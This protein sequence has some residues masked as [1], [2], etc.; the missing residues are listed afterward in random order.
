MPDAVVVG[1]G[2][3]GLS[4]AIGLHRVGWRV[5]VLERAERF[6]P[7]GAGI[8]LWPNAVRALGTLGVTPPGPPADGLGGIRD[9]SGRWLTR[10]DWAELARRTGAPLTALSRAR[11]HEAL[12]AAVPDGVVQLG[13]TVSEVPDADLVVAADGIDSALRARLWPELP[14]PV[15]CGVTTWRGIAPA[16]AAGLPP[17][18]NSWGGDREFGI[19]PLADGRVYWFGAL[20]ARPPD[21]PPARPPDAPPAPAADE[22]AEAAARFAD[23]HEPIGELIAS[24]PAVLRLDIRRLARIPRDYVRGRV[25]LLGDAAHA[26]PPHLGQ[27]GGMAVEDAV[28]LADALRRAP[29]VPTALADYTR[30][31]RPRTSAVARE[32]ARLGRLMSVGNPAFTAVRDTAARL[33][34]G[35]VALHSIT[36]WARWVP[37][38]LPG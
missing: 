38:E 3:G 1:A 16:P 24:T 11:L 36:R 35:A 32:S 19:V 6:A 18:S 30:R 8:T 12:L 33:L 7:V 2:I 20:P 23:W 22:H 27:G 10:L 26:M 17:W 34:P 21:A 13:T 15:H 28:T 25:V 29:D 37:P 9:R 4:A 31:R 5:R 14:A